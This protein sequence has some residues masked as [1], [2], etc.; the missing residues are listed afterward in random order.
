[1]RRLALFAVLAAGCSA[2]FASGPLAF[3]APPAPLDLT[4][5]GGADS[6]HPTRSFYL[7]WRLPSGVPV[8][9][10]AY[11]VRDP[12]GGVVLDDRIE[13]A[14]DK[15]QLSVPDL[16][17]AYTAEVRLFD[18]GGAAGPAATAKLR[19]DP[20]RPPPAAP[21]PWAEWIGR[22]GFPHPVRIELGSGPIPRSGIRGYAVAI[23]R[24]RVEPCVD[25]D[26]CSEGETDLRGAEGLLK[27]DELP[28]GTSHLSV[29]AVSGAGL[30]S[31]QSGRL[32]LQVDKTDPVTRLSGLPSGWANRPVA[33]RVIATD[34]ASGME[35][36]GAFT[37]IRVAGG[38]P[39]VADGDSVS[40]TVVEQGVHEVA[41]FARDAAGNVDDGAAVNVHRNA[42]PATAVVRIDR[43][44]PRV[45]F[46]LAQ[47]ADDPELL[48]ASVRDSLSGPSAERGWIGVRREGSGD[49]FAALETEVVAGALHARW[50][51]EDHPLGRYEFEAVAYDAAGN[52]AAS[53]SRHD[54][55]PMVL[56]NPLKQVTSLSAG[57]GGPALVW[58]RCARLP[59]G[60]RCRREVV[61]GFERRPARR[62]VPFGHG[63]TFSGRLSAGRG[64]PLAGLPVRI[65]E[66]LAAGPDRVS[67]LTTG[68]G[69]AF[70]TR[71]APGPSRQIEARYEGSRHLSRSAARPVRLLVR[72]GIT[73]RASS[74]MAA[75]GGR[76]VVF[77]GTVAA[78]AGEIP[79]GGKSV[80]LQFRLPGLPW[81]EFRTVESDRRGRFRYAYRFSD[82]DS[83]GV[84]FQFRAHAPAQAGWSYA[85][86]SSRPVTV[87]GR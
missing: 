49:R 46:R 9:A 45:G 38:A 5:E 11:L 51:S 33:L 55:S 4:V 63:T 73:L 75:I 16:P 70:S 72:G 74:P 62:T 26:L 82:D 27:I 29:V 3:G 40:T 77:S 64:A 6:W 80:A 8:A 7:E 58:H 15:L 14:T 20:Q 60:R 10:V 22:T 19:Y 79:I 32:E 67:T 76:P 54:G 65:V 18:P 31:A 69:G 78:G 34:A 47:R 71:L 28:E 12:L 30:R 87:H 53:R 37:A 86:G 36:N 59:D 85:P 61:S 41:Y 21:L 66:D 48:E 68:P 50:S 52:V 44:P 84:A 13:R 1:L 35:S 2:P 83:R 81:R 25:P 56:S 23:D 43:E 42:P 57:F 39:V 17:G 24:S